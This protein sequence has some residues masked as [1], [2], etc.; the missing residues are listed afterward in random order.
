MVDRIQIAVAAACFAAAA[1]AGPLPKAG[2]AA[3]LAA[4]RSSVSADGF[5]EVISDEDEVPADGIGFKGPIFRAAID[6]IRRIELLTSLKLPHGGAGLVIHV[7]SGTERDT[8]VVVRTER[9]LS[10]ERVTRIFLPSPGYSDLERFSLA[11]GRAFLEAWISRTAAGRDGWASPP[12]WFVEGVVRSADPAEALGD[13]LWTLNE[14]EKGSFRSF[15]VELAALSGPYDPAKSQF[16]SY[17]VK[18]I[19]AKKRLFSGIIEGFSNGEAINAAELA[20]KLTGCG[21]MLEQDIEADRRALKLKMSVAVPGRSTP[22]DVR[23]FA[24]RLLLYPSA[25]DIKFSGN[26]RYCDF[27]SAIALCAGDGGVRIAAFMKSRTL[28]LSVIGRGAKLTGAADLY[29]K[30]LRALAAGKPSA[31]LEKLLGEADAALAQ[32]MKE[33]EAQFGV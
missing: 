11:V 22:E 4:F 15:P 9:N 26:A 14:W 3:A 21:D 6:E 27:R 10:G 28:A 19:L 5:V 12:E 33:A 18:W 29:V 25:F 17:V 30:F 13:R 16:H 31:E 24:A 20:A 7:G 1:F 23:F 32:A 2:P 8:N